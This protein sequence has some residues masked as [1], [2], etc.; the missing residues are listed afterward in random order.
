[1]RRARAWTYA[2]NTRGARLR[3]GRYR[4]AIVAIDPAGNRSRTRRAP[5][6]VG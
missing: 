3:P 1:V 4:A 2:L 5:F 6:T